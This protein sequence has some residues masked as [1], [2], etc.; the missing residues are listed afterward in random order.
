MEGC[1]SDK[2]ISQ[3]INQVFE[4]TLLGRIVTVK[5]CYIADSSLKIL[6]NG[7]QRVAAK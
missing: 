6:Q 1:P 2:R 5:G 3:D 7:V 4:E